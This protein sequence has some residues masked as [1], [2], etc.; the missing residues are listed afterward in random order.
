MHTS[1]PRADINV[2]PMIDVMLVLLIIFMLVVPTIG[3]VVALPLATNP[4]S[5]P[6]EAGDITLF[7]DRKGAY[8][9][10]VNGGSRPERAAGTL[11]AAQL[12]EALT[13][14][15]QTRTRD[16]ILYLKADTTLSFDVIENAIGIARTAGVRVLATVAELRAPMR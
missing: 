16:R 3:M 6:E 4:V 2:T 15:Y 5:R 1:L 8:V 14:L 10:E 7:I 13:S 11:T 9:L 12:S